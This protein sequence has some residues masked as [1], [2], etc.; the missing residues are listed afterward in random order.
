MSIITWDLEIAKSVDEVHGGWEAVRRGDA[1]ISCV[2]LY[3]TDSGRYHTYDDNDLADAMLHLNS[4]D[5]LVGFNT[6]GFD[7][8]VIESVTGYSIAADQYD[9]LEEIWAGLQTRT[10]GYKLK[11]VCERLEIGTKVITG[12]SAPNLYQTGRMGKLFDY[13]INDVHLTRKLAQWINNTGYILS[14]ENEPIEVNPPGVD[15]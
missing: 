7:T 3:D 8:P 15:V 11:Q 6:K 10:K 14:P 1:G 5:I 12:D 4:A 9:I 2:C 13:C